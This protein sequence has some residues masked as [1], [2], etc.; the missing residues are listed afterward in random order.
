MTPGIVLALAAA[1]VIG[2]SLGL[3]GGGGSILTVPVLVYVAGVRPSAAI[4]MS[5]FVVGA[6]AA[7]ALIPHARAGRVR[8]RI[9]LPFGAAGMAGAYAGGRI[10]A[11]LPDGLLIAGFAVVMIVAATAMLRRRTRPAPAVV[12]QHSLVRILAEGAAVGLLTGLM[13]AGGGFLIVPALIVLAGLSMQAA[14][15]TSLLIITLNSTA[16]LAGHLTTATIDWPLT[17]ALAAL[18]IT[19]SLIG[20]RLCP[21]VNPEHLRRAFGWLAIAVGAGVLAGQLTH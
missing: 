13:G 5:L 1:V 15:G 9:G 6:T 8:W 18:A 14:V 2:L 19:G 7:V 4:A 20:A 12:P 10:A 21:R 17:V 16:G 3:L 11:H